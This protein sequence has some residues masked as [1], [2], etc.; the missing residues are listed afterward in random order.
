M[1]YDVQKDGTIANGRVFADVTELTKT[2]KGL[3][4][5]MK[6]DKKGNLWA[7]GPGGVLVFS[8]E[9]KHLGT[10]NTGEPT[11]NCAFGD[12]GSTLYIT[13]NTYLCRIKTLAE[14][15]GF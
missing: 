14:G 12:D 15:T 2:K 3:P 11:G 7:T 6:V 10:I 4:D 9:G 5:G 13:A 8:P 1:V